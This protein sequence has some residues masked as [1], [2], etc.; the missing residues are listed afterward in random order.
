MQIALFWTIH[1]SAPFRATDPN[2]DLGIAPG[3]K[4]DWKSTAYTTTKL[5]INL[6]KESSDTFPPL[7]PVAG[8]L[9]AILNHFEVRPT[10][11]RLCH[12]T[13]SDPSKQWHVAER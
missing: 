12:D 13:Y 11:S 4:S 1:L 8:G 9:S 6:V 3:S 7:K 10:S 2:A 5:A